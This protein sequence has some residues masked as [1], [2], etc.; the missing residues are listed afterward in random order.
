MRQFEKRRV[1]KTYLAIVSGKPNPR[2]TVEVPIKRNDFHRTIFSASFDG[3]QAKTYFRV[4]KQFPD[5]ALLLVRPFTGRT[6][7]IRVHLSHIGFPI[8]GDVSYG[9]KPAE[10]IML[11]AYSISFFHPESGKKVYFRT[12]F[13]EDFRIFLKSK[14]A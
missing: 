10:R 11:H 13:P 8:L 12:K 6:H 5:F 3:R 7:Q 14:A 1:F 4:V 2:G 9:G